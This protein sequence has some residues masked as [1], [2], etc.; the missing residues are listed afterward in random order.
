MLNRDVLVLLHTGNI[1][2]G[3]FG[4]LLLETSMARC[5]GGSVLVE[6]HGE[7]ALDA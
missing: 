5:C 2:R 7:E 6:V 4:K 1:L 3:N